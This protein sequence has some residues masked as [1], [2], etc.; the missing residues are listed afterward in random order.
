MAY[1]INGE[2]RSNAKYSNVKIKK[3]TEKINVVGDMLRTLHAQYK[4]QVK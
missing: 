1:V 3:K 4:K 2:V